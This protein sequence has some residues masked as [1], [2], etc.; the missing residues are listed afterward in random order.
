MSKDLRLLDRTGAFVKRVTPDVAAKMAERGAARIEGT[1]RKAVARLTSSMT[2]RNF[3][4]PTLDQ[5]NGQ[6]R[7][8]YDETHAGH[9]L[10]VLKRIDDSGQMR[11]WDNDLTFDELRSG[12]RRHYRPKSDL[13]EAA[14]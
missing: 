13:A 8:T 4:R 11:K 14:A 9:V 6:V 3:S 7:A 1:G 5:L 2:V 10:T 12:R